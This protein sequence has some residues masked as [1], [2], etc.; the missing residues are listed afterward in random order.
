MAA[1]VTLSGE[2][3]LVIDLDGHALIR[4]ESGCPNLYGASGQGGERA[5]AD[6]SDSCELRLCSRT[7]RAGGGQHEIH[8]GVVVGAY[9][10][11]ACERAVRVGAD[12]P[13]LV[14]RSCF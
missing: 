8:T 1:L 7:R 3:V 10:P 14:S 4:I 2:R 13:R 9:R 11:C 6:G 12:E 5:R